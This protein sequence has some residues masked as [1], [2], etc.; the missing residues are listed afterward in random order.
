VIQT[1]ALGVILLAAIWLAL[2]G[3]VMAFAPQRAVRALAA[4]GSTRAIH[5]GEHIARATVGIALVL[6]AGQSSVPLLFTITGWFLLASSIVI[7]IAPRAWHHRFAAWW[8]ARIPPRVFRA[9]ALPTLLLG[10]GLA[11]LAL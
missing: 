1:L 2:V 11:W 10:G 3:L 4:M 5:F 8:A 9:L 7:M 6:R